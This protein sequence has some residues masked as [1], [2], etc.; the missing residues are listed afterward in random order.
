M[1]TKNFRQKLLSIQDKM[2][3]Y[4]LSFTKDI[5]TAYD[6]RQETTL[7]ALQNENNYKESSN[8]AGWIFKIMKN[9]YI[10]EYKKLSKEN[11][12]SLSNIEQLPYDINSATIYSELNRKYND[13][14]IEKL[15][16]IYKIPFKMKHEGYKYAEIAE[17]LGIA[18]GTVKS[19]IHQARHLL[20]N[21]VEK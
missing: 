20:A 15:D 1:T 4:A 12:T 10:N 11:T 7:K 19:R 14:I 21:Q 2:L 3:G 13:E 6:L 5:D 8:F 17:K 16:D 18:I 9:R